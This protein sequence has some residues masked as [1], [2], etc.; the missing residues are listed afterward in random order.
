[1]TH[2]QGHD[3]HD[4]GVLLLLLLTILIMTLMMMWVM[5]MATIGSTP[6]IMQGPDVESG[7]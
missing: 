7:A 3:A 4:D 1:L 5:V 6:P 2:G